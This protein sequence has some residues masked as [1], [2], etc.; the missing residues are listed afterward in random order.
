MPTQHGQRPTEEPAGASTA[1]QAVEFVVGGMTCGSCAAR[2]Q[3]VLGKAKGVADA[4]VNFATGRARV[5]LEHPVPDADLRARVETIGYTLAP[6]AGQARDAAAEHQDAARRAWG[7]RIVAAAPAAGFALATMLRPS[8]M[9]AGGWRVASLVVATLMEFVIGWPFLR[10]AARRARRLSANMDTLIAV[11]T[12]AA[13]GFSVWEL[14]T[15]GMQLY[16]ETAILLIA[17][18]SLG[19]WFEARARGRAGQAIR[20]LLELGAKQA[21]VVR[22]GAEA[23]VPVEEVVVGDLVRV[24]PGE[25]V[26]VDGEVVDGASAVDESM[27]TGESVPVDKAVGDRVAGATLNTSGALTVRAIAVGAD[28]ALA[29]ILR[30]VEQAQAGKG[31][32]Q[33]LADRI[34]AV[35]VPAVIAVAAL[36]FAG[37]G[38]VGG[39][40]VKGLTA[41]VAVLIIA[42]PCALGLAT[43]TAIMVGSGRGA[44]LG[45]LIKSVEVLERTRRITTVVFDKTGTLTRGRMSLTD[46]VP[47]AGVTQAEL[48]RLAGAA[49]ASS[50][51]PIGAAITV[52]ARA[53]GE[54]PGAQGFQALAG[55]GVR[56]D[57]QPDP[58]APAVTVWVGRRKLAAEAGLLVPGPLEDAAE[59]LEREGKTVVWA[60]WDGEVRGVLAVADILKPGARELVERLHAM[61]LE[62]AMLTGDNATTAGAIAASVG[63]DRVLAE[64]LPGDKVGEV[65]RLQAN[66]KAVAMVGDGVN[67][68]PAL[69]QA[70]LGVAI[71]SGTDVAIESSDL[72]LL[73]GDLDGVATAIE[74]SRRTY[75]TIVQNLFWAFGYNAAAIPL[76]AAGLLSPV[77]AGA[78]MAFSSVSV[79]TNSLRLRRFGRPQ[80]TR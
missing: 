59:R 77:I 67:D 72:T 2:V 37:W 35:F 36:T 12:L 13:Y 68:A 66:G 32:V 40:A 61:G 73:R 75:R 28:T 30:L 7:R 79:V 62:A 58:D 33:R 55:H 29:Q 64:V 19:R 5:Q 42:C 27:L 51:H 50:E 3:R 43:P 47:A 74:L 21:R 26:P 17:F 80:A 69:V 63:I 76:A 4:E 24:R 9:E 48:L 78:A 54:L 22:D 8:L 11:G 53:G 14:A 45:V 57:V 18:L 31:Q 60:G 39:D 20:A 52:A 41:A 44:E 15:G 23:L 34:S 16:F 38:L 56:A 10:E 49:E 25:K 46:A 70:D 6:V 1:A 71:G 65:A